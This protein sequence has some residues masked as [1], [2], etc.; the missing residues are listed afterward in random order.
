VPVEH[1]VHLPDYLGFVQAVAALHDGVTA[2][3]VPTDAHCVRENEWVL[4][5]L[6]MYGPGHFLIAA[7]CWRAFQPGAV[8]PRSPVTGP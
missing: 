2:R 1:M 4:V 7:A 8:A 3:Y 5:R 6:A